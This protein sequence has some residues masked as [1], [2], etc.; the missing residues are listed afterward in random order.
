MAGAL[1][2]AVR[3][4]GR[5]TILSRHFGKLLKAYILN[6]NKQR[7]PLLDLRRKTMQVRK[8][9][10]TERAR[11]TRAKQSFLA[12]KERLLKEIAGLRGEKEVG[13]G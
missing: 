2:D 5:E 12:E 3:L 7:H 11:F 6:I 4:M 13:D 8:E 9:L 10:K 1:N